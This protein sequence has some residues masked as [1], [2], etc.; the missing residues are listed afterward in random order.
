MG[1]QSLGE[2]MGIRLD[3]EE[4]YAI[5]QK[6]TGVIRKNGC[7]INTGNNPTF[8]ERQRKIKENTIRF[9]LSQEESDAIILPQ[10]KPLTKES[11]IKVKIARLQM[12]RERLRYFEEKLAELEG[13]GPTSASKDTNSTNSCPKEQSNPNLINSNNEE[14]FSPETA[15]TLNHQNTTNQNPSTE[16]TGTLINAT[17]QTKRAKNVDKSKPSTRQK[18]RKR[19]RIAEDDE[20]FFIIDSDGEKIPYDPRDFEDFIEDFADDDFEPRVKRKGAPKKKQK[21][22]TSEE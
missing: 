14:K 13:R 22:S 9:G 4:V 1:Q 21:R 2:F 16:T 8:E 20:V 3:P 12:L 19:A 18:S 11:E 17:L 15:D 6:K 5:N 7:I 10:P